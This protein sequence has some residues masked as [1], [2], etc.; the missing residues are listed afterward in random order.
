MSNQEKGLNASELRDLLK[1][2]KDGGIQTML[3]AFGFAHL[4]YTKKQ[5]EAIEDKINDQY[6]EGHKP[7]S[8]AT[9]IPFGFFLGECIIKNVPGAHWHVPEDVEGIFDISVKITSDKHGSEVYPFRRIQKYWFDRSDKLSVML[10]MIEFMNEMSLDIGYQEK[11]AEAEGWIQTNF[12]IKFR[13]HIKDK[14]SGH[15]KGVGHN[16]KLSEEEEKKIMK[17]I[18]DGHK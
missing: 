18:E 10:Q 17:K 3:G 8:L 4:N 16:V 12:G 7:K 5:L 14:N 9:L 2:L 11:R 1:H 6:P 13:M 15:T